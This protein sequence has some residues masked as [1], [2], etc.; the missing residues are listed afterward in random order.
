MVF[1]AYL[2]RYVSVSGQV[3]H[4]F[5]GA[6]PVRVLGFSPAAAGPRCAPPC[7]RA[8]LPTA[9]SCWPGHHRAA[10]SSFPSGPCPRP[11][12]AG[13][14]GPVEEPGFSLSAAWRGEP[15]VSFKHSQR[16]F[17]AWRGGG[18]G[19]LGPW[20]AAFSLGLRCNSVFRNLA[21]LGKCRSTQRRQQT[22]SEVKTQLQG[23]TSKARGIL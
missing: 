5:G 12:R 14:A 6:A 15:V 1:H 9:P 7:H 8:P 19:G 10:D 4:P 2:L 18:K 17:R 16:R 3:V 22:T 23:E 13:I 21:A 20:L 11:R